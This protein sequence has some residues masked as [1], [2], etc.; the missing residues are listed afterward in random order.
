MST[1]LYWHVSTQ[2]GI[3]NKQLTP[4]H[5]TSHDESRLMR[6]NDMWANWWKQP[7]KSEG[8]VIN[9]SSLV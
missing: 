8:L 2:A 5:P 1:A 4:L 7:K 9:L 3:F 6:P